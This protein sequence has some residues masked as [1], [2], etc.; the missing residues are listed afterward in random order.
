MVIA[1]NRFDSNTTNRAIAV[2]GN[3]IEILLTPDQYRRIEETGQE[4]HEYAD[5]RIMIMPGGSEVHS[6]IT[7][8]ITTFLNLALR[9][10]SFE[11]YNSDLRIWLPS[12]N[13]GT[14]ADIF[15]IDGS[16]EFGPNRR[17]EV[18]NPLLIIEV[19]SPSTEKYDRGDKF[20]KYRSLPSFIEYVLVAQDE[21]YVELYYKQHGEKNN[22]WQLEIYDQIEQSVIFHSINVEVP[23]REIYRRTKLP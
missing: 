17:D 1:N 18:F 12:L 19:L 10:S 8:D 23:I 16:P 15:V 20:R 7:V 4:R 11:T 14:Y 3:D 22:L 6:R 9:D 5:G 13:H 21:P 2:P